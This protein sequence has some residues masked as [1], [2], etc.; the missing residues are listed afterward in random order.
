MAYIVAGALPS[1]S[2]A[3]LALTCYVLLS[4]HV[5]MGLLP[6]DVSRPEP[7][8]R[9]SQPKQP[10]R[11]TAEPQL[12]PESSRR[13]VQVGRARVAAPARPGQITVTITSAKG[14]KEPNLL[15]PKEPPAE[16]SFGRSAP[17]L[18]ASQRE[19]PPRCAAE[20]Q[21]GPASSR[22]LV[23]VGRARV[24]APARQ[25]Q[26]MSAKG[27]KKPNLLLPKE[28]PA[29]RAFGR[30]APA[31]LDA[32][33]LPAVHA[34]A[35]AAPARQGQIMS[36]KGRKKPNLLL[37][38]EPPAERA[39]GRSAPALLDAATLPAVH[40]TALAAP[41]RQGQIMSAKGRKKP[42]LLLPK[43]PPAE[44]AFGRSAPALL[45]AAT[46]PA[47]HATAL[48]APARQGQIMSAK[49]RK[50]PNLLLPKE[51]PA[52]R[53]FGRSAPALLDAATL[54]AVHATAL[55]R[56]VANTREAPK[57]PPAPSTLIRCRSHG[58][59]SSG[60]W[61]IVI[62]GDALA[63]RLAFQL[64]QVEEQWARVWRAERR[65]ADE[66]RLLH[67]VAVDTSASAQRALGCLSK[68]SM[69]WSPSVN[70]ELSP[71]SAFRHR[72]PASPQGTGSKDSRC[73][74]SPGIKGSRGP[75][76]SSS[77]MFYANVVSRQNRMQCGEAL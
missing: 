43:E 54:P 1:E 57:T 44:R 26:I 70:N 31:L 6:R 32:A 77:S 66:K 33:T 75:F 46:L 24:A 16:R 62:H 21:L 48:A 36:A 7:P 10:P 68:P 65:T 11:C 17:A 13:L 55:D 9:A 53:A 45:D 40:A 49:G 42:N 4:F 28:P 63:S 60:A 19:Q 22:R 58:A 37:P 69:R 64:Q 29:E 39:F 52:E 72:A 76:V 18:R 5:I 27:R 14:R 67:G 25:G 50:K 47:V 34:T 2:F 20:P 61:E 41:A 38:K 15:L 35:L 12:D 23:Q 8:D 74:L 73:G 51:P 30:S 3:V 59:D 56:M 71:N